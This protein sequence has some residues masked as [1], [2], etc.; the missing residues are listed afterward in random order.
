MSWMSWTLPT[1]IFFA[2]LA[3]MITGMT[4]WEIAAPSARRRG[5]LP[6]STTRGDRFFL[7][8]IAAGFL[9]LGWVGVTDLSPWAGLGPVALAAIAIGRWA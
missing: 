8:L 2:C 5:L 1:A 9:Q 4:V 7:G 6:W 3:A